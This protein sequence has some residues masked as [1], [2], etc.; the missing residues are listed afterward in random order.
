MRKIQNFL[1][2]TFI[3]LNFSLSAQNVGE[4]ELEN[5]NNALIDGNYQI[6]YDES[7]KAADKGNAEGMLNVAYAIDPYYAERFPYP[8]IKDAVKAFEYYKKS[9]DAGNVEGAYATGD[10]YRLGEGTPKDKDQAIVYYKKAY[11]LGHPEAANTIYQM[12]G[13]DLYLSYLKDCVARKNFDAAK[14]LSIIYITGE[15]VDAN[16]AEAMKYLELGDKGN[17]GGCQYVLG[18]LYRNGFKKAPDG[19]VSLSNENADVAKAVYYF[20][21][22]AKNGSTEALNNL[23]EMYMSGMEI[24]EDFEKSFSNFEKSCGLNSGYG[25]YMCGMM[26]SSGYVVRDEEAVEYF[27]TKAIDL[28]YQPE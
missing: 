14:E 2:I 12:V 22:A 23:G 17:H 13:I 20:E 15:I 16:I 28:G 21:L 19:V 26:I 11:E 1:S 4:F 8:T 10:L 25:C 7:L 3:L 24:G 6:W 27:V 9:G 18:Y 5:A